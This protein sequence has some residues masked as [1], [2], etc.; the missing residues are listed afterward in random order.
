M[1]LDL[2]LQPWTVFFGLV[3]LVFTIDLLFGSRGGNLRAAILWSAVWIGAGLA[4]GL[5]ILAS[6][7]GEVAATY[8]AAYLL[9]KALSVD[10]IFVFVLIFSQLRIPAHQQHRVLLLGIV[11][12]LVMRAVMIWGGVYLLLRFHWFIYPFAGLLLVAVRRKCGTEIR[13]GELRGVQHVGRADHPRHAARSRSAVSRARPGQA[14]G[15]TD[16][17]RPDP[18]RDHRPHLRARLDPGGACDHA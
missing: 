15:D 2:L 17:R 10:N 5:W 14:H 6:Q 7:G 13:R 4:F 3:I 1:M 9:E 12:A 16:A 8:Y 18:D 11:G